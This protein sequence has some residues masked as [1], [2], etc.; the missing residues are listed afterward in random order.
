MHGFRALLAGV[1]LCLIIGIL[2]WYLVLA[3][4][5]LLRAWI[6]NGCSL[7]AFLSGGALC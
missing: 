2:A 7:D 3:A 1:L 5:V 4:H 6:A